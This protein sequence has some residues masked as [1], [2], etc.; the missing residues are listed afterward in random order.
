MTDLTNQHIAVFLDDL[1]R[2]GVTEFTT[3]DPF[4]WF[5]SRFKRDLPI[6]ETSSD[7]QAKSLSQQSSQQVSVTN[8]QAQKV[9]QVVAKT[10]KSHQ[11]N[12]APTTWQE[13]KKTA[14]PF[15]AASCLQLE[16]TQAPL[17]IV[18]VSDDARGQ[19]KFSPATAQLWHKMQ[20]AVGFEGVTPSW[21]TVKGRAADVR[22]LPADDLESLHTQTA[23]LIIES[24]AK[25][26]V[27]LGQMAIRTIFGHV[28]LYQ[29]RKEA[30]PLPNTLKDIYI[31]ASYHPATLLK[32]PI[33]KAQAWQDWLSIE[34]KFSTLQPST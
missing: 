13:S 29:A 1:Q 23:K 10:A 7:V 20:Q 12:K 30:L 17:L 5:A 2:S 15:D 26:V 21:L 11:P 16:N 24:Q 8:E 3:Q 22:K 6:L 33:L 28:G 18:A 9:A 19:R 32:E 4:D 25:C 14:Q 27:L 34:A 31:Q